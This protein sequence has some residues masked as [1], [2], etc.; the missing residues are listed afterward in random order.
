MGVQIYIPETVV[1]AIRTPEEH[2]KETLTIELSAALYSRG[3]L[4]FGKAKQLAKMGKYEFG[5]LL[6]ERGILRHY[7]HKELEDDLKYARSQ[8]NN[9]EAK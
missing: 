2:L 4:S 7:G 9:G 6:G 1:Q 8:P 5:R 3:L